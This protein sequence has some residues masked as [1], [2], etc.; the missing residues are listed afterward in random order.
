MRGSGVPDELTQTEPRVFEAV[1]RAY[2]LGR[3]AT[4]DELLSFA[5]GWRPFRTWMSVLFV[6]Q[7]MRADAAPRRSRVTRRAERS[8]WSRA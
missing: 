7:W 3:A 8:G 1:G 6:S 5:E 2:G 4:P